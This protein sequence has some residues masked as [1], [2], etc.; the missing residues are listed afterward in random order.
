M[1]AEGNFERRTQPANLRA[2]RAGAQL[3]VPALHL[4]HWQGHH[5]GEVQVHS[6]PQP[7][8]VRAEGWRSR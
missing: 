2:E 3:A 4:Q 1:T 8:A 7:G 5:T 6:G